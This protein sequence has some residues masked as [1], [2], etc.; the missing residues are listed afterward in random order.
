MEWIVSNIVE[1]IGTVSGLLYLYLEIKQNKWLWPVGILTSVMYIFVFY[2][3]K[4]YADMSLQFYYVLISV[5]GWFLWSRGKSSD[6]NEELQVRSVTRPLFMGLVL[7]SLVIYLGISYVLVEFTDS[8]LPYWDAFTT[9]LSIV[10]TWMLA[11]KILEQWIVWVIVNVVSL[12]LYIYKGLY[13]TSVLFFFYA[14]LSVVGYLQW[15]KDLVVVKLD[16]AEK[17]L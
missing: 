14:A 16:M 10:A 1:I 13:P 12:A 3:S 17:K 8:P 5:Y 6:Q 2:T 7:C 15:R 9:A 11:K 4:F